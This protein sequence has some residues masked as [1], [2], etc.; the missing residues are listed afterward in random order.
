MSLPEHHIDTHVGSRRAYQ[1]LA[2]FLATAFGAFAIRFFSLYGTIGLVLVF[3]PVFVGIWM[4]AAQELWWM[5]LPAAYSFGGLFWFGFRIYTHE[6][7]LF[8]TLLALLPWLLATTA[9][10][11]PRPQIP[12]SVFLLAAYLAIHGIVSVYISI[13]SGEGGVGNIGRVYFRGFWPVVFLLTF[14]W[15][16]STRLLGLVLAVIYGSAMI[17]VSLGLVGYFWPSVL[18]IPVISF[19]FP[20]AYTG[21]ID[22]RESALVLVP[23]AFCYA[24]LARSRFKALFH[25]ALIV[26]GGALVLLGGSR[27]SLGIFCAIALCWATFH[28][29]FVL[30]AVLALGLLGTVLFLSSDPTVLDPLPLR[31]R[32]TLSIL[33]IPGPNSEVHRMVASSDYWHYHLMRRAAE[34]WLESPQS[35]LVGHRVHRF[36]EAM[37]KGFTTDL[38]VKAEVSATMGYYE[39]G[40]WTVLAVFGCVGAILYILVFWWLLRDIVF[41]LFRNG[42]CDYRHAFYFLAVSGILIWFVFSWIAGHLPSWQLMLAAIA[43]AAHEDARYETS[44]NENEPEERRA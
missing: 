29:R 13:L 42:V 8:L 7:A 26:L 36:D 18:Y 14:Y 30:L 9:R 44:I 33:V 32:R 2:A 24:R 35:F 43:K 16:G 41:D 27:V 21:G 12:T 28:K 19:V 37:F 40:L 10:I 3:V 6:V 20:A 1:W 23:V 39:S 22:L 11:R 31:I 17:R 34:R 5:L 25:T 15:F 4:L 38:R